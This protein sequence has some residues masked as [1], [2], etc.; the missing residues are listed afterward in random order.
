MKATGVSNSEFLTLLVT[1]S[2]LPLEMRCATPMLEILK[3]MAAGIRGDVSEDESGDEGGRSEGEED[4]LSRDSADKL[5]CGVSVDI[6]SALLQGM[7]PEKEH[8]GFSVDYELPRQPGT[9]AGQ[10]GTY[11]R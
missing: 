6:G 3:D 4:G 2:D 11:R 10:R 9:A 1:V 5:G 8:V 7:L